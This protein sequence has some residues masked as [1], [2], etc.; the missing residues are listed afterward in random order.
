MKTKYCGECKHYC[1]KYHRCDLHYN[2]ESWKPISPRCP[3]CTSFEAHSAPTKGDVIRQGSNRDLAE[4][5]WQF[6]RKMDSISAL[7]FNAEW[8]IMQLE[9]ELNQSYTSEKESTNV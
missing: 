1:I 2:G 8:Q 6:F 7:M 3:A 9:A 5:A 4:F